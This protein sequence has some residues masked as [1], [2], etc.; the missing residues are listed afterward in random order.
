MELTRLRRDSAVPVTAQAGGGGTGRG[1][2]EL[3]GLH[4]LPDEAIGEHDHRIAV[5]VGEVEGPGW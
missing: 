5:L 4:H 3:D 1:R 2:R